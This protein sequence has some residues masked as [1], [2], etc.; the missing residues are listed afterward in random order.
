MFKIL[1]DE[2]ICKQFLPG[3]F[4]SRKQCAQ[5]D[6]KTCVSLKHV[7]SIAQ[8]QMEADAKALLAISQNRRVGSKSLKRACVYLTEEEIA[9][10]KKLSELGD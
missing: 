7:R 10:L 5:R 9:A 6:D 3:C 8:A 2:R 4:E 1:S